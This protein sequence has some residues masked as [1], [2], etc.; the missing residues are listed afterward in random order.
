MALSNNVFLVTFGNELTQLSVYGY[1][2]CI[3]KVDSIS[4]RVVELPVGTWTRVVFGRFKKDMSVLLDVSCPKDM[5]CFQDVN[6]TNMNVQLFHYLEWL[7]WVNV[8][9]NET[10]RFLSFSF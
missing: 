2:L 10:I 9:N 6:W 5:R 1:L 7:V 4:S 3:Y 8:G